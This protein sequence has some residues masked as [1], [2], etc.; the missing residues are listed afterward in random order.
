MA[1]RLLLIDHGRC[2]ARESRARRVRDELGRA[3]TTVALCGPTLVPRLADTDDG[4]F[5]IHL[6][7]IA[8]ASHRFLD[9]VRD[10]SAGALLA[11]VPA[12]SPRLLGSVRETARQLIAEAVDATDP[13]AVF[14]MHAGILADLA[15]ETGV[16]VAVHVDP[17][18]LDAASA[19]RA[20]R[21]IVVRALGSSEVLVAADDAVAGRLRE[22]WVEA[23]AATPVESWPLDDGCAGRIA[24]ACRLAI[25]RR[26]GA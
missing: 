6:H 5:G 2:D 11:A 12:L 26:R 3:G 20:M 18:D 22:G 14:V 19:Q 4:M 1:M 24:A 16:P 15:V 23:D 8:A 7:D 17:A 9:A 25:D 21:K 10:G 13:D